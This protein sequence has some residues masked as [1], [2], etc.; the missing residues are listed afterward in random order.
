M[1]GGAT[2]F[3]S[4][5]WSPERTCARADRIC[6][7]EALRGL[8][9]NG[10]GAA[11]D[12]IADLL[13][14]AE[15]ARGLEPAEIATL[16]GVQD[17]A[18]RERIKQSARRLHERL[19][20]RRIRIQT[21]VCPTN[22]CVNEC[23]YC[24]LRQSNARL[25]RNTTSDRDLRREVT[26]LM[27]EGYRHLTLV[28]GDEEDGLGRVLDWL[29][30]TRGLRSGRRWIARVDLNLNASAPADLQALAATQQVGTYHLY[31][32]TYDP[33]RYAELHVAG[34]KRDYAWR[35]TSHDRA[36]E[37][38]LTDVGL[39]VLLGAHD[40]VFEV[41]ALLCHVQYL[42]AAHGA[43]VV[44]A[45]PRLIPLPDA[46]LPGEPAWLVGD[47]TFGFLVAVTRLA[48][49][50]TDIILSTPAP[51]EVRRQL[52]ALGISQ[53]SVGSLSYPGVYSDE[54]PTGALAIG[55]PRNL[56]RLVYRLCEFG[57]VPDFCVETYHQGAVTMTREEAQDPE[58]PMARV[59]ADALLA[60]NEYALDYASPET[61]A[62]VAG[63]IQDG[64]ALLPRKVRDLTLE[65]LEEIETG[66]RRQML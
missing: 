51:S 62:V 59:A 14:H 10:S 50:L 53:V 30:G 31:Q 28:C 13:Y 2:P 35:L 29:G 38:G 3:D 56:E 63:V 25:R 45:Y 12:T 11:P 37:A 24:P 22:R 64:L 8:L 42:E 15:R 17:P 39:G 16:L 23:L 21:P 33:E 66:L 55:R 44:L 49:P 26:A 58:R 48:A 20:A 32:E 9:A 41:L 36:C 47:D 52:Y 40:P 1:M 43:R 54:T 60:L 5:Q 6:N 27:D 18:L 61:Q 4:D 46:P 65:L 7:P 57:F 19:F 34:P